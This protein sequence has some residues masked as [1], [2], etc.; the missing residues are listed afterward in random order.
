MKT[1]QNQST[2]DRKKM[3]N[4]NNKQ[5]MIVM[6]KPRAI[7]LHLNEALPQYDKFKRVDPMKLKE[8]IQSAKTGNQNEK[9]NS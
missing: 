4:K 1:N 3:K 7:L 6:K 2:W 5:W 8:L 9:A